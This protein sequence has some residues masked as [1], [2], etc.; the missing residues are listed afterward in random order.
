MNYDELT[1]EAKQFLLT[2]YKAYYKKIKSGESRDTAR[3]F[4]NIYEVH[5]QYFSNW[6][7]ET[8]LDMVNELARKKW[9]DNLYGD[10]VPVRITLKTESI[11]KLQQRFSEGTKQVFSEL[12]KLKNLFA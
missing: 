5:E 2:F 4:S 9:L 6:S 3:R 10:D 11:A 8:T 7:V 1:I 12:T